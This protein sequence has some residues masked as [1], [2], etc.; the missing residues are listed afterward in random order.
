VTRAK[1]E[2]ILGNPNQALMT[3]KDAFT[4]WKKSEQFQKKIQKQ[5]DLVYNFVFFAFVIFFSVLKSKAIVNLWK[6]AQK[7]LILTLSNVRALFILIRCLFIPIRLTMK[8]V[9]TKQVKKFIASANFLATGRIDLWLATAEVFCE[10]GQY[11]DAATCVQE[12]KNISSL[13]PQVFFQVTKLA[14]IH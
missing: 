8:S 5:I 9:T 12:A 10:L 6:V 3:L 11:K 13:S 7:I 14:V 1:L 2:Q 4:L